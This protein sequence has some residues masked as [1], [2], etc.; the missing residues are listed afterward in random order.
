LLPNE[1]AKRVRVLP[2]DS[3]AG[4]RLLI[5]VSPDR[6]F[7]DVGKG[8]QAVDVLVAFAPLSL[9]KGDAEALI[10]SVLMN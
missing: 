3:V 4:E 8:E 7:L 2:S 10:P 5:G 1:W 6:T 9:G